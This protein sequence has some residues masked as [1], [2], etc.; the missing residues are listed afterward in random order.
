MKLKDRV[1]D[2]IPIS[3]FPWISNTYSKLKSK[4]IRI[5][6][7]S[8]IIQK[9]GMSLISPTPKFIGFG[10]KEFENRFEKFFKIDKGNVCLDVGAC[11][12][13]T[14]VPMMIKT[15]RNGFVIVIEP[16]TTNI[17]FLEQNLKQRDVLFTIIKKAVWN[18]KGTIKFNIH[19][20]PT[21]HSIIDGDNRNE[22]VEVECDTLDNL[23]EG[24]GHIDFAKIDVQGAEVE[25][26]EGAQQFL[27]QVPK[28]VVETHDRKNLNKRTY[29][30]VIEMLEA[31]RY[32][33][34]Y[35][36]GIVYAQKEV[37]I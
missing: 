11:I 24:R 22:F 17:K 4:D 12:G 5:I 20:T 16:D 2:K 3:I 13:D 27:E 23:L 15:G 31:K 26:L 1:I 32:D 21:G 30:K 14:T 18:K 35:V 8:W 25:V 9:D 37:K 10:I 33:I 36:D 19:K 29:P 34:K 6:P 28:L 7:D